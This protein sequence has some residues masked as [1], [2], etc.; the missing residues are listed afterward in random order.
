MITF[1]VGVLVGLALG[2]G[3]VAVVLM[4]ELLERWRGR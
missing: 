3:C 1:L 2:A 4:P